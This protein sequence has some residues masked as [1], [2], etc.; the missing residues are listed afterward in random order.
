MDSVGMLHLLIAHAV[1]VNQ[2][3]SLDASA[4]ED[5]ST[6]VSLKRA[7]E[8]T[9]TVRA[10]QVQQDLIALIIAIQQLVIVLP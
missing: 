2:L 5:L 10:V 1:E 9:L 6:P 7:M 3:L 8:Y 4:L